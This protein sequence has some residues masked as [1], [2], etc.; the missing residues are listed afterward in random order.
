M[1][2]DLVT[3][4]KDENGIGYLRMEDREH[5]N[6][7]RDEFLDQLIQSIDKLEQMNPKVVILSGLPDVFCAGA[8]KQN[9]LDLCDGKIYVKDLVISEK[10]IYFPYPI[11]AAMEG[12]ALGGGLAMGL[13]CDIVIAARESRYGAV[14]MEM[15]FTP[16]MG[17]T[18]LLQ[19]MM[20]PYLANEM[21][22][23][24]ARIRGSKLAEKNTN[25]NYILPRNEVMQK[26]KQIALQ[27]SEKNIK[28]IQLLKY[29]LS[30]PKKKLLIDARL[31]EDFMHRLSFGYSET[32][33]TIEEFYAG[34]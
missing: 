24:G 26:A 25:I 29:A 5:K 8:E 13:C 21:M 2:N 1:P 4:D 17:T 30:A 32:R 16:G 3:I 6:I 20:G 19:L 23:T 11:I 9:L 22:F 14:F 31:Q 28:S 33:K 34:E 12:H 27:I 7:F 10:L 18:T 15:G